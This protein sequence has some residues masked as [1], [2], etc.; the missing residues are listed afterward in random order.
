MVKFTMF[1]QIIMCLVTAIR[2]IYEQIIIG[3]TKDCLVKL[4]HIT[5]NQ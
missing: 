3:Y 5:D 2:K 4:Y 1:L